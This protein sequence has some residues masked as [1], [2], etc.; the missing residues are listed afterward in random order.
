MLT[1]SEIKL[2]KWLFVFHVRILY[3]LHYLAVEYKGPES[4]CASVTTLHVS[5]FGGGHIIKASQCVLLKDRLIVTHFCLMS[6]QK[7]L[8]KVQQKA[9]PASVL[10]E[11][12][13]VIRFFP[14]HVFFA[15]LFEKHSHNT[16][17][18][19]LIFNYTNAQS[20]KTGFKVGNRNC[21]AHGTVHC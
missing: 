12:C 3:Y 4:S 2:A 21:A 8:Q 18:L 7:V 16:K 11:E 6:P 17:E 10:Q 13:L 1:S 9:Q 20:N 19:K 15:C 14:L 5:F